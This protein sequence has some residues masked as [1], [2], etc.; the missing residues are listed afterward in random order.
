MRSSSF[1][2]SSKY[3]TLNT[4]TYQVYHTYEYRVPGEA[5]Y[6]RLPVSAL[7]KPEKAKIR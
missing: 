1:G 3:F 2:P 6:I 4:H 7:W 5:E